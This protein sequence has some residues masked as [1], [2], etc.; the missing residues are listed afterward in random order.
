[1]PKQ[2]EV[3]LT[4]KRFRVVRKVVTS[5]SGKTHTHETIEHPGAVTLLP[6]LD[7]NRVCLI[8]NFRPAVGQTLIELPA[9]TLEAGEEP[10]ETARRELA[11]ETGYRAGKLVPLVEFY[12]S[13]GILSERMHLYVATELTAG[14]LELDA[15]EEI[16][17]TI[18]PWADAVRMA[19][20]G[21]IQDAKT[22]VGILFYD[23]IRTLS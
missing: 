6:M 13:P 7:D 2:P 16:D 21:T 1:M 4:T 23:R 5:P 3:L 17:N 20:D 12:M 19:L 11:E 15:G 9:G 10:I 22:I 18:V 8:R 14:D